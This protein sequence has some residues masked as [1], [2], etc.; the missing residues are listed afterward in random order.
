ML[1]FHSE[2]P[3]LEFVPHSVAQI[4]SKPKGT[5]PAT[6]FPADLIQ[7]V[8][9]GHHAELIAKVKD[10]APR[11]WY[12]QASLANGWSRNILVMQI[13]TAAHKRQGGAVARDRPCHRQARQPEIE[14]P[15]PLLPL[16]T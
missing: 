16:I 8:P 4:E 9:W 3:H 5:Q 15:R 2:Y 10:P 11:R 6:L 7:S 14:R 1:A 13:E 12:M